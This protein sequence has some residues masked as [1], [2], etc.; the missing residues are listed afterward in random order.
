MKGK[1]EFLSRSFACLA[2]ALVILGVLAMPAQDVRANDPSPDGGP[3]FPCSCPD[4]TSDCPFALCTGVNPLEC[5][6]P[7]GD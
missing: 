1:Y 5:E 7:C 4:F 2:T 6:F 3:I